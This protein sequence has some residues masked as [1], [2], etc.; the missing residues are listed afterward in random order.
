MSEETGALGASAQMPRHPRATSESLGDGVE[1]GRYRLLERIG[2][3]GMA[4]VFKAKSLGVEGFEKLL[5]IKRIVPQL[6]AHPAF[7]K[8]FV[9]EAKLAVRLSHANIVQVFD[10]GRFERGDGGAPSYF[11][12]MEYVPGLDLAT[13]LEGLRSRRKHDAETLPVG[14]AVYVVGEIAKALDHAHRRTD[15]QGRPLNVV[16]RDISPHNVLLSWDGDVKVTDFGIARA[17]D[18]VTGDEEVGEGVAP[19]VSGKIAFMSPEQSRGEPTDARSDLFSLGIVF[20]QLLVGANPFAAP[21]RAETARRIVAGEYPPLSIARPD[22]PQPLAAIVDRLLA[23]ALPERMGTAAELFEELLA[24]AYTTGERFGASDLAELMA[25]LRATEPEQEIPVLNVLEE[26]SSADEK[27][28]VEVPQPSSEVEDPKPLQSDPGK[29]DRREVTLLVLP[30]AE[31]ARREVSNAKEADRSRRLREVLERHGAWVEERSSDQLIAIFGLGD[32]DG[33]DGDAAVRAGLSLVRERS[34]GDASG[35]GI[36]S[37]PISVDDGGLP[38]HDERF[39]ALLATASRLSRALE[40]QVALSPVTARLVRRSFLTEPLPADARA[41]VEGVVVRGPLTFEAARTR[42]VGRRNELKKLG[43]LLATATRGEAQLVLL[44][45]KTGVGKSRLLFEATRRLERGN[46]KVAF[47]SCACPLNGVS[48]P[49]S[50]LREMLHVLCGTQSDDD[51][52]RLL[53]VKPRLRALGLHDEEVDGVL[54]LLGVPVGLNAGELRTGI[55]AGFERMVASLS[56]DKLH[57]FAFDDAQALDAETYDA[58]LRIISR[59]QRLRAVFVFSQRGDGTLDAPSTSGLRALQ[60]KRRLHVVELGELSERETAEF[61]ELQVGARSLPAE[62]LAY[63]RSCAGGHPLFVEELVREL[64][65][66]GVVH[67]MN[68]V[69]SLNRASQPT[70]P[71]TLRTLIADRVSRLSQRERRVLQGLAI[72]GEPATTTVLAPTL[73]QA[74]PTI[75]RHLGTLEQKGLVARTAVTQVRFASPLYQEIVLDA[76]APAVRQ[77][78]HAAAAR[79]YSEMPLG[80]GDVAERMGAHHVG[81]GNK[82][83]AVASYWRAGAERYALGQVEASVRA[84]IR[85]AELADVQARAVDELLQWLRDIGQAVAH[86][87]N[88]PGLREVLSTVVRE[89]QQRGDARQKV[90]ALVEAARALAAVNLFEDGFAVLDEVVREELSEPLLEASV[91]AA[92]CE[93]AGRQGALA[94]ALRACGRLEALGTPLDS[95]TLVAMSVARASTGQTAAALALLERVESTTTADDAP[96]AVTVAKHRAIVHFYRR[97]FAM[98]ARESSKAAKLALS[99]GLRFEAALAL[100]N[101]GDA[102]DRIGDHPRAYAAF[103]ESLELSRQLEHDRLSNVNQLH[104]CILDGLRNS[105]GVEEKLKALIRYADARGYLSDVIEGRYLLARLFAAHGSHDRARRMLLEV[106]KYAEEQGDSL[107]VTDARE[108]LA[109]V[110][111]PTS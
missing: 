51:P 77:E 2:L 21:T 72:L 83:A 8:M 29:G 81:S 96:T 12:A 91:L 68:G 65:D 108:L 13:V 26:R 97:D 62:L 43:A 30:I 24:F 16:H 4:E 3:G 98:A 52:A 54:S 86:S 53:E 59:Q 42:F 11:I 60:S 101:L 6:A 93:L 70:A 27:T 50:A 61:V 89:V 69:A 5:V 106:C 109:Q 28:P 94:R 88:G 18:A 31:G 40:G 78:L 35:V 34:E 100:H 111:P 10:L 56:K 48:E 32:T 85:G 76:M 1:Y 67:V 79:V 110:T 46:F 20:Y 55:R 7:V 103:I 82:D 99:A 49:W 75:D 47:H 102:C 58:I 44:Q 104:L 84:M 23:K 45:G 74:L 22:V 73:E 39:A 63:V 9:H 37:G 36:H 15:E 38:L 64:C 57:G 19:R 105:E 80:G 87:R 25:T 14:A 90:V 17:G 92:E 95:R 41:L 107:V 33:R 66:T 71:R